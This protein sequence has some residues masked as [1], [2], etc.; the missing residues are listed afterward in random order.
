MCSY[1][2]IKGAVRACT[3][4]S[5]SVRSVVVSF[6]LFFLSLSLYKKKERTK[7]KEYKKRENHF[8]LH[9]D[10]S[11]NIIIISLNVIILFMPVRARVR[12]YGPF[13]SPFPLLFFA[14]STAEQNR[15][16]QSG[17]LQLTTTHRVTQR[18]A[19]IVK[20]HK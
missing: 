12:N 16:E 19:T 13:P 9:D 14:H 5:L 18:S 20:Q 17:A 3:R 11:S 7:E 2:Y 8:R 15:T 10:Y 4:F 6:P 1:A